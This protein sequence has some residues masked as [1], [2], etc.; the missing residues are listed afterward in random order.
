MNAHVMSAMDRTVPRQRRGA[1]RHVLTNPATLIAVTLFVAVL[2][3]EAVF[4]ALNAH[5]VADLGAAAA[6]AASVP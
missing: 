4:F 2:L 1:A 6:L 5:S 3:A